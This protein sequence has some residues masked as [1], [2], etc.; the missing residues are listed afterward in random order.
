MA[1]CGKARLAT[2]LAVRAPSCSHID[3]KAC[4]SKEASL[5]LLHLD[6]AQ[7]PIAKINW[8]SLFVFIY[9]TLRKP[10]TP[11]LHSG[12]IAGKN[13]RLPLFRLI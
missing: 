8:C 6:H 1:T 10:F 12:K 5:A 2:G 13:S 11:F 3:P 7:Y 4:T 9:V